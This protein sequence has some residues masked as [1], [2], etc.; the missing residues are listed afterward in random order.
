MS[1]SPIET[2]MPISPRPCWAKR[3]SARAGLARAARSRPGEIEKGLVDRDRLD[4]GRQPEHELADRAADIRVFLHVRLDHHRVR[5]GFSA[6][7]IGMAERM[8]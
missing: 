8:P 6:L 7:N 1:A 3:A 2:V 5:A 4:E